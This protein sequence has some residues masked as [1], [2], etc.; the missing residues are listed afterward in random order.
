MTKKRTMIQCIVCSTVFTKDGYPNKFFDCDDMHIYG[1]SQCKNGDWLRHNRITLVGYKVSIVTD[2]DG[3]E[4]DDT[5]YLDY[6]RDVDKEIEGVSW[7]D[8]FVPE[9][10]AR[11]RKGELETVGNIS[12]N[13]P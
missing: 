2:K 10:G 4:K 7:S 6:Y 9:R 12:Q 3:N 11:Q 1:C 5:G 8:L 13:T